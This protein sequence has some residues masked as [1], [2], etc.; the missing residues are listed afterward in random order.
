MVDK[1]YTNVSHELSRFLDLIKSDVAR[2]LPNL[3]FPK[4]DQLW[5]HLSPSSRGVRS[6]DYK[7][8]KG[9]DVNFQDLVK[10]LKNII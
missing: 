2:L 5:N 9:L 8:S 10:L 4:F 3:E 7:H 1:K 6:S